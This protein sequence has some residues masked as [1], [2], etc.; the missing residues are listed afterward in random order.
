VGAAAESPIAVT[1]LPAAQR[2]TSLTVVREDAP[3]E[4][5]VRQIRETEAI[6]RA[7]VDAQEWISQAKDAVRALPEARGLL[8]TADT[9]LRR[10]SA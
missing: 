7:G 8:V 4:N 5:V 3:T 6:V 2:I 1:L 9:E 10:L